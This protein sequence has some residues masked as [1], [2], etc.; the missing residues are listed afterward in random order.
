MASRYSAV[1]HSAVEASMHRLKTH[2][3]QVASVA[4]LLALLLVLAWSTPTRGQAPAS[5]VTAFEGARVIV[6]DGR[7][8]IENATIVVDG[9]R[10]TQVGPP[11][12]V[13]VPANA[14]RV[15][16]AGK[17]VMPTLIDTHTHLSQTREALTLDLR[18]RA[19]YGVSAAMSM[20]QDT[21]EVPYQIR[22]Q[23]PP[24]AARFF[25]AG[26]GITAP[27][28]GRSTVPFWI[29]T[30]DEARKAVREL[31]AL[32]VDIVKIWVDD[33][34]GMY[35]KLTPELYGAVI[36][37][38]HRNKL[39]VT[40]HLFTLEDAKGLLRAGVDAFAHGV[41]DRDIDDEFMGLVKQ[42]PNLVL[43]PNLPDRGVVADLSWLKDSLPAAEFEKLQAGNTNR[44][45]AQTAFGIQ[46]RNLAKMNAAGVKIALGSDGN[47]PW[48]PHAELA[49]M[50]ASGM[51]P[52]QGIVAATRNGAEFLRMT[53]TGTIEAGKSADFLVLDANPLDDITNTRRISAVYL[54]GAAVD[55]AAARVTSR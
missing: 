16:L 1:F 26:R 20:G 45:N 19:F 22:A 53:D 31:A 7:A 38:A 27:E 8:P 44:P 18:R 51:T 25:T 35:K 5:G 34:E 48:A 2:S 10:I 36:D 55:R 9:A 11:A 14:R 37:E 12:Q 21:G 32:K 24:G 49:D 52:M 46:A 39:R 17:T 50:V 30:T 33:R 13:R 15:G 3:R 28:P 23:T 47:T 42:R 40:A 41:R 43:V 4:G 54:R 6:G 29:T